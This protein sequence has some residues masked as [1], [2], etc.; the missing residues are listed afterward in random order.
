MPEEKQ[1]YMATEFFGYMI[2][3]LPILF[4]FFLPYRQ[5]HLRVDKRKLLVGMTIVTTGVSPGAV[6]FLGSIYNTPAYDMARTY[7]NMIFGGYLLLGTVLYWICVKK[8]AGSRR[9]TYMLV[10]QYG[11]LIYVI[12]EIGVKFPGYS[13]KI[14]RFTP[15]SG[16]GVMIYLGATLLTWPFVYRY[17]KCFGT[18]HFQKVDRRSIRLISVSSFIIF[19]L[20]ICVLQAEMLIYGLHKDLTTSICLIVWMVCLILTDLLAYFIYF[21]CLRIE[22]EKVEMNLRLVTEEMQFQAL[23]D[24][25]QEDKRMYHNMRHHFRTLAALTEGERY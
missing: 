9:L 1:L 15:Y 7:G 23:Q 2:Q 13:Y 5:E 24:K 16:A 25:I 3:I 19:V 20:C 10:F 21:R 14:L 11:I 18:K 17:L 4:L 12:A 8:T 6:C 22:E